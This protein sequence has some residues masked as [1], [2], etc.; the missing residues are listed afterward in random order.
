MCKLARAGRSP[1]F[2]AEAGYGY[3]AAKDEYYF[4]LKGHVLIDLRGAITAMTVTSANC[5][6]RD[7]AYDMLNLIEERWSL[8][9]LHR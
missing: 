3:C 6:E 8:F 2:R 4:R 7:A 1:V 5:D 9:A